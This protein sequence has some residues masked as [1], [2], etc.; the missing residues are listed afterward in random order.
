MTT[1]WTIKL[2][3][4]A[5]TFDLTSGRYNAATDFVPPAVREI[6]AINNDVL[7]SR[8]PQP[9]TFSFS[10]RVL[11][12]SDAEIRRGGQKLGDFLSRAGDRVTPMYLEVRQNS[13]IP[14]EPSWGSYGTN[15]RYR[16]LHA[17]PPQVW[18]RISEADI[19]AIQRRHR[20][21]TA[22]GARDTGNQ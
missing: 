1:A 21:R 18:D 19:R 13:D 3:R 14:F 11:G 12:A 15:V 9:Q 20:L 7:L 5:A 6:P 16:I 2:T 4:G 22:G 17:Q 8:K 10:V